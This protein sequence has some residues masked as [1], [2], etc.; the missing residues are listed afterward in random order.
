V[1]TK[2]FRPANVA[3]AMESFMSQSDV[4]SSRIPPPP[5]PPNTKLT[6]FAVRQVVLFY[7]SA[8]SI[9]FLYVLV[10]AIAITR[11]ATSLSSRIEDLP[12][13][14]TR[15]LKRITGRPISSLNYIDPL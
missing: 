1:R 2:H 3:V 15:L 12:V 10:I 5:L 8:S 14:L 13:L 6:V 11:C 4:T 7:S 9:L